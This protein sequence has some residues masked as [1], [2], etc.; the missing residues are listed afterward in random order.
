MP[1]K[2]ETGEYDRKAYGVDRIEYEEPVRTRRPA[3]DVSRRRID[4]EGADEFMPKRQERMGATTRG[5]GKIRRR[6]RR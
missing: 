3:E 5:E 4:P 2:P 1:Y 6:V